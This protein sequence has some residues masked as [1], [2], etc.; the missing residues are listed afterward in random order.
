MPSIDEHRAQAPSL[1]V[2]LR[3]R[4]ACPKC[5]DMLSRWC[6]PSTDPIY[7][8][9]EHHR[10]DLK[11]LEDAAE[12][13]HQA[14]KWTWKVSALRKSSEGCPCCKFLVAASYTISGVHC[15]GED[16]IRLSPQLVGSE[17]STPYERAY[18]IW[19][20]RRHGHHQWVSQYKRYY[21]PSFQIYQL[22][23]GEEPVN[24]S[25]DIIGEQT[26]VLN[27]SGFILPSAKLGTTAEAIENKDVFVGRPINAQADF[28]LIRNWFN[29]CC[30]T[31]RGSRIDHVDDDPFRQWEERVTDPDGCLPKAFSCLAHFRL[32]DVVNKCV[33]R[34]DEPV[35]YAALSYVWGNAQRLLLTRDNEEELS[36][37][38]A[39]STDNADLP[40][41]FQDALVVAENLAIAYLWIDALCI[42]QDDPEQLKIHM[43]AMELVYSSAVLTIVSDTRSTDTGIFGV[44]IPRGPPQAK[45]SWNGTN[46]CSAKKTFG[47]ALKC[48]PWESRAWYVPSFPF[49]LTSLGTFLTQDL[50]CLQEKVFSKR[51][52]VFTDA[53]AFYHCAANT[54]FEDTVMERKDNISGSVHMKERSTP[55]E[56]MLPGRPRVNHTA[57]ES[58]RQFFGRNF[59]SLVKVY[60]RR[61]LLFEMDALRAFSGVLKSVETEF[62]PSI[63][64]VPSHEFT[65]G[66]TWAHTQHHLDL[67][68]D[69][70]PSWS[71]AGW[72]GNTG[73]RLEFKQCKRSDADLRVSR[74]RHRV[75]ARDF[76]GP[77]V[78]TIEWYHHQID[79]NTGQ[80]CAELVGNTTRKRQPTAFT[81]NSAAERYD[82][83]PDEPSDDKLVAITRSPEKIEAHSWCLPGHPR[84]Q[85]EN[86]EVIAYASTHNSRHIPVEQLA[87]F[88]TSVHPRQNSTM[89]PLDYKPGIMPPLSHIIRFY[90][91]VATVFIPMDPDPSL[92]LSFAYNR[93]DFNDNKSLHKVCLPNSDE[94]IAVVDL[95]PAWPGNGQL[96][97]VVY[98]SRWCPSF[99]NEREEEMINV[100]P[101]Q[102]QLHVLLVES[103]DGWGEVKRRVQMLDLVS[104]RDWRRA[105]PRWE[106]V[107]LALNHE[108]F[109]CNGSIRSRPG[110]C[111]LPTSRTSK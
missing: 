104:L 49:L 16:Y 41:T 29:I 61:Q 70:F 37:H 94:H 13:I 54:W 86:E 8:V 73:T 92:E 20:S 106:V 90:T 69:A 66:M 95:D 89:P 28:T 52:L 11:S 56:K 50:R 27:A 109:R 23:R 81:W 72:R 35:A 101:I 48:S 93:S 99:I 1:I 91:S 88:S 2:K 44:S 12:V 40:K 38:G 34:V 3:Y 39:L 87:Q 63:W 111:R 45:F 68:R 33:V 103:V 97:T 42:C 5:T 65:R 10:V 31:H 59:W 14:D 17:H 57:Y 96:H 76:I 25:K 43:D 82:H 67:R 60:S 110:A 108:E 36:A 80:Y 78:W 107:S 18:G 19:L 51:L 58:H 77:S 6:A 47:E 15:T 53:Q 24:C 75:S 79:Q 102:E 100:K 98:I 74:G 21:R 4:T 85:D 32:V 55:K 62:G 105:K 9:Y 7:R 30:S 46:Y 84:V 71:W 64:G 22:I 83:F 26:Y